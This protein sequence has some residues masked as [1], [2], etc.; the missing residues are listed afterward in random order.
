ME[1]KHDKY[2]FYD[3]GIITPL[4]LPPPIPTLPSLYVDWQHSIELTARLVLAANLSLGDKRLSNYPEKQP[5]PL[6]KR[7]KSDKT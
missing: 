2:I 6:G 1:T 4:T 5:I 7:G 3:N